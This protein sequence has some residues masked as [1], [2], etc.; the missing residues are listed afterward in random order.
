MSAPLMNIF[1]TNQTEIAILRMINH[2]RV[3]Q[4]YEVLA[5]K[6]KV[7]LILELVTGG[8]RTHDL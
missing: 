6:T 1:A 8:E 4:F 7:Y 3:V 2:P 5:S